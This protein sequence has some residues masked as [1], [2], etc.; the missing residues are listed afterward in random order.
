[1]AVAYAN[2]VTALNRLKIAL[3]SGA[4]TPVAG[5]NLDSGGSNAMLVVG[6]SSLS[7]S[8]GILATF[9]LQLPSFSFSTRTATLNGV[10]LTVTGSANGTA[11]LA[12]L[13]DSNS[14]T[15]VNTLTVGTSASDIIVNTTSIITG[16]AVICTAGSFT[17]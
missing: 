11:S 7:G 2:N 16:E 10:P 13:R 4:I 6:N 14:N 9:P 15:I 12:E 17:A 1:M 8:V 5:S 3:G